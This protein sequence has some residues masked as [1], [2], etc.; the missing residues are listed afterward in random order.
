MLTLRY[1]RASAL[2]T[3]LEIK[4]EVRLHCGYWFVRGG[5]RALLEGDKSASAICH[6]T[7]LRSAKTN[8]KVT[9]KYYITMKPTIS[10]YKGLTL[11]LYLHKWKRV[12]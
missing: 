3:A 8:L 4:G 12:K 5:R 9:A 1:P 6:H 2:R 10:C 7:E 11:N